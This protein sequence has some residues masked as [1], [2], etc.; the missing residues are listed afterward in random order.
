[1]HKLAS[2]SFASALVLSLAACGG[3]D[4]AE[5]KPVAPAP[6]VEEKAESAVESAAKEAVQK[7]KEAIKLD[8]SSPEAFKASLAAAR[9]VAQWLRLV[10]RRREKA[11]AGDQVLAPCCCLYV[12]YLCVYLCSVCAL[13]LCVSV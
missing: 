11:D 7:V 12:R 4:K 2:T 9:A 13:S 6:A 3:G 8:T 1:M 5:E 10:K